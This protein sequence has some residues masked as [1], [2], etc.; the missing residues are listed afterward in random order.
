M[1]TGDE[2]PALRELADFSVNRRRGDTFQREGEPTR[3]IQ[4]LHTGWVA[5]SLVLPNGKRLIQKVHLPGDMLTTPGMALPS[6]LIPIPAS[7][8]RPRRMFLVMK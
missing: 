7:P 8:M 4:L 2:M 6:L 3:G 1:P 5:S